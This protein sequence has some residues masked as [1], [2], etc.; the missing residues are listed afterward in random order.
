LSGI[1]C[2]TL[3]SP[4][5]LARC[6]GCKGCK[7]SDCSGAV[8][9]IARDH[10]DTKYEQE[11]IA[12][13]SAAFDQHRK[14]LYDTFFIKAI[15]PSLMQMSQ[16]AT[17]MAM[18]QMQSIGMMIDA[19]QQITMQR[20]LQ[21]GHS[22]AQKDYMPSQDICAI[23]TGVRVL[24][25]SQSQSD[26]TLQFLSKRQMSRHLGTGKAAG[27]QG[28]N[29]DMRD[30]L[31]LYRTYFCNPLENNPKDSKLDPK[32]QTGLSALCDL[33]TPI[34]DR[35]INADINFSGVIENVRTLPIDISS[36]QNNPALR[37]VL[38]L[39]NNLYGHSVLSRSANKNSSLSSQ[40]KSHLYLALRSVAAQRAVAEH[41]FNSIVALKSAGSSGPQ[42]G[43]D[44]GKTYQYLGAAL[45]DLGVPANEI[46]P[47]IGENPSMY[48][49][50][51]ILS[52]RLFQNPSFF[53]NLYD[54]P[55]NIHRKS[56][57]LRAIERMLDR[58]IYD[59]QT[60][61]E[62]TLSVL[63]SARLY[64]PYLKVESKLGP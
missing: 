63:L 54:S 34:K 11:I 8:D 23:G 48:A 7:E 47:M 3:L 29:Q 21:E 50:L 4:D 33:S 17:A 1:L 14:W 16:Q 44:D 28:G 53:A 37:D 35:H 36:E 10:E 20:V 41:S 32:R 2:L 51:E 59:S 25:S 26:L 12:D 18:L 57:A 24:A 60:R 61:Q 45:A 64:E 40:D 55:T 6:K 56:V 43:D 30:R 27:A 39:G 42:N 31:A 62:M 22:R 49:Q 5:A 13:N 15:L 19:S 9:K 38:A 58:A 52:K 46:Y